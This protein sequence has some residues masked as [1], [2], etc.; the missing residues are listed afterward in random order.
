MGP[1]CSLTIACLLALGMG[2]KRIARELGISRHTATFHVTA[3]LGKRGAHSRTEA[4]ALEM[5]RG[6]VPL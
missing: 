1:A 3:V 4:V 6:L 2:N 5:R